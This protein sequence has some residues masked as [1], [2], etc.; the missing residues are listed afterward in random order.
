MESR[1]FQVMIALIMKGMRD[2][3]EEKRKRRYHI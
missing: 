3:D 2:S 1:P